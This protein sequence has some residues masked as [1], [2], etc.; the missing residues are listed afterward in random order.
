MSKM[1]LRA[2]V[3]LAALA[4]FPALA[5]DTGAQQATQ[6]QQDDDVVGLNTIIVTAQRREE[7]LQDAAIPINAIAGDQLVQAGVTDATALNKVAPALYVVAAGGANAGYFVRGVGN[8]SN[9]GYTNP[10]VAFNLDGVYIGRPS[11]TVA[12][13]LDVNRVE[14]LKGPQGTLYGRNATGGAV[15]VIPNIPRLG[16]FG[17]E[18]A[19]QYGSYDALELTGALNVPLADGLATRFAAAYSRND[20]YYSDG[21]GSGEDLAFRAQV[22]AELTEDVTLRLSGDYSTQQGTGPGTNVQG[23]YAFTPFSPNATAGNFTF[24]PAPASVTAPFTGLFAPQTLDFIRNTAVGAPLYSPLTDYAYPF[25]DDSYWGINAE[26]TADLGFAE[27]TFI[28]AYRESRLDNQFN[29]PPFKGA[30]NQNVAEQTSFE[31]RL[32]GDAGPVEWLVGGYYFDEHV[33]G[34]DSYNQFATVSF[35]DFATDTRSIAAFGRLVFSVTDDLRLVGGLRFTDERREIDAEVDTLAAVCLNRP[36]P[37]PPSCPLV[38]TIPVGLTVADSLGQL[39]PALFPVRSPFTGAP[40]VGSYPYGPIGPRG[41]YAL[42]VVT[43]SDI[44]R[45]AGD[46]EIT[47]RAAVEYDVTPENLVYASFETGFRAGGFNL[48]FGQEEYA[49]EYIDAWTI[50]SKNNFFDNRL[51]LNLEGFYWKY[52][53]QQLAALGVD[54][55][56]SNSFYTRNVGESTIKGAEIDFQALVTETTLLRGGV[57]YLDA[58]YDSFAYNQIDLSAAGDPPN[59]LTPLTGCDFTQVLTPRRSFDIDCSGRPALNAPEW[60]V[61]LGVQQTLLLGGFELTGSVDGRYRSNRVVGFNYL[62]TSETGDDLTID[63]AV[64]LRPDLGDWYVTAFVRNLTDEFV[65]AILQ[66]GAGNVAAGSYEPPRRYGVRIG[67]D[68]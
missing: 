25:R 53:G 21:T 23:V 55:R 61:N 57:Q 16:E 49:P 22:L 45:V 43:P 26:L 2:S 17:A 51:Q 19:A 68:F 47:Y 44:E 64:T 27:L 13:F 63:A 29:G 14:V 56:G 18:V 58:T 4:P 24:V 35:N 5:Q 1:I 62:P 15:N 12:S 32:T 8:F 50:G 60:T 39:A 33:E 59:F 40:I 38:P 28:P 6:V 48:T 3:A 31:A 30:V 37:G 67:Y 54:G 42:V 11:S 46:E 10:A 66:V 7:T 65:P 36:T 52:E 9:N 34:L 20:G 41:P